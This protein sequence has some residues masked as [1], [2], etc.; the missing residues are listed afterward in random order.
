M[1]TARRFSVRHALDPMHT[2]FEFESRERA[3]SGD[4]GNDFLVATLGAFAGGQDFGFPAM[5]RGIA[6]VHPKQI[7]GEQRGFVAAGT[8][9]Y[10]Q[11][12]VLVI[13]R[14]L[15]DQRQPDV[16]L[17]RDAPSFNERPFLR[18]D[19]AQLRFQRGIGDDCIEICEIGGGASISLYLFHHRGN[20]GEFAR[21]LHI[22][23]SPERSGKL[24]F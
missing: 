13:H 19:L 24:R 21:K 3:A 22:G 20:L 5:F 16:V 10:L 4:L 6:L 9:A 23:V 15:G 7:A 14:I 8:G 11:N 17:E 1:N 18:C 2:R 12:D